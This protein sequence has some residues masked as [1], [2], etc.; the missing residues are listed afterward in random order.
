MII[1]GLLETTS[2]ILGLSFISFGSVFQILTRG[3]VVFTTPLLS[4]MNLTLIKKPV[5][6]RVNPEKK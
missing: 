2:D 4:P 1:F 6:N 3:G 5:K